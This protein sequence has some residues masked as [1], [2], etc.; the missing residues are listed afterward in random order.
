MAVSVYGGYTLAA[1]TAVP[2]QIG[3][4]VSTT[5]GGAAVGDIAGHGGRRIGAP[6]F[7]LDAN[8]A[9]TLNATDMFTLSGWTA[10]TSKLEGLNSLPDFTFA[11]A[12]AAVTQL[13][14]LVT[15]SAASTSGLFG[16]IVPLINEPL[17]T[18]MGITQD[19]ANLASDLQP[20]T[21]FT[22]DQLQ[23]E[24]NTAIAQAFGSANERQLCRRSTVRQRVLQLTLTF[25]PTLAE[26]S[27]PLN[28]QAVGAGPSRRNS[29]LP[30]CHRFRRQHR[31]GDA[32][33]QFQAGAGHRPDIAIQPGLRAGFDDPVRPRPADRRTFQRHVVAGAAGVDLR[34]RHLALSKKAGDTTDPATFTVGLN[35]TTPLST[36][37]QALAN[38]G[39]LGCFAP[40]TATI[41][42][43]VNVSLPLSETVAGSTSSLG[44]LTLTI[45]NLGKFTNDLL[46]NNGSVSTTS[47]SA[48]VLGSHVC[49][50]LTC[51]AT[52]PGSSA[53]WTAISTNCNPC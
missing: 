44:T 35:S 37:S 46:L 5:L 13:G 33:R 21:N 12:K 34:G 3:N 20:G 10:D 26:S 27:V 6:S 14:A 38:N 45:A 48:A 25:T 28:I 9:L 42:G 53:R 29:N 15:A 4:Y 47:A 11:D 19:F 2:S 31:H 40:V 32:Q 7:G 52:I 43:Q 23:T 18:A 51:W 41:A 8:A 36:L 17:G 1:L 24:L 39:W 16:Q 49:Q 50:Y 22:L 30:G